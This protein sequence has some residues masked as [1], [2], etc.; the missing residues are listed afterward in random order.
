MDISP[1][2]TT[3]SPLGCGAVEVQERGEAAV[4]VTTLELFFDLVFVFTITQLTAVLAKRPS[5][6]GLLHVALMLVVIWW[7][8][9]PI[10]WRDVLPLA[11]WFVIGIVAGLNTAAKTQ[12]GCAIGAARARPVAYSHTWAVFP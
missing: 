3:T 5:G 9:G 11:P 1:G 8:R 12:S 4:R 7:K 2:V 6:V 10:T